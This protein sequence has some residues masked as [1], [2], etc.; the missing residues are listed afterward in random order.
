MKNRIV[1]IIEARMT[2]SRLPGKHLL[3]ADGK[4]MLS[5]LVGR[6]SK[7][8][9]LDDIVIATTINSQ[10]D[11]LEK[12]A[13]S[14]KVSV[15]RGSEKDVMGRVIGA[16]EKY[17]ASIICEVTGDCPLIDY[18]LVEQAIN[19]FL[20]NKVD[21]LNY[22][23][24]GGLPDGMGSQV[25][26]L[27]ALKKSAQMTSDEY[28]HEHVTSHIIKNPNIFSSLY[29]NAPASLRAPDIAVTLDEFQDYVL[30]KQ[31]I[32]HFSRL[33]ESFGCFDIINLLNNKSEW[34]EINKDVVRNHL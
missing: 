1:A 13:K 8:K 14:L 10:D 33:N 17:N 24:R 2:S 4:A 6:L 9:I 23:I 19:S 25:F 20:L 3:E 32:E 30:I 12:L 27:D 29:I 11:E 15:F 21:Y 7:I 16:G 31:I 18:E 34:L 22:G 5:H 28:D 26:Y